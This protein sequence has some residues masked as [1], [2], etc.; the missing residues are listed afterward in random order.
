MGWPI[1]WVSSDGTDLN[2]DLGFLYTKQDL[3]PFLE[4][5]IPPSGPLELQAIFP[6][7]RVQ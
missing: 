3:K 6:D 4:G 7:G 1:D 5:E 2:R